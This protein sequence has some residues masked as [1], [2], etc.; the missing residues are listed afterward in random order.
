MNEYEFQIEVLG[1]I[2]TLKTQANSESQAREQATR[3]LI[4]EMDARLM[5]VKRVP[6]KS[7]VEKTMKYLQSWLLL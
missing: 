4:N 3:H 7:R 5:H 2:F 1:C 6:L